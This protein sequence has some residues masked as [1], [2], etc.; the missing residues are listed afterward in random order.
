MTDGVAEHGLRGRAKQR[1]VLDRMVADVRAG[2]GAALLIRG[3]AGVGKSALLD[4]VVERSTG[5]CPVDRGEHGRRGGP[6][7]RHRGHGHALG[8][9]AAAE[10]THRRREARCQL[11]AAYDILIAAAADAF[12]AAAPAASLPLPARR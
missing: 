1:A 9:V 11:R 12:A 2:Q 6:R 8:P 7:R 5:C 10:R 4:Y 3:D